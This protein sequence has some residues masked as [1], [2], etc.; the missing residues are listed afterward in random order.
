MLVSVNQRYKFSNGFCG[1]FTSK[2]LRELRSV[3]TYFSTSYY[4]RID[5]KLYPNETINLS[6]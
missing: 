3:T 1:D 6:R 2:L 4:Y 5:A